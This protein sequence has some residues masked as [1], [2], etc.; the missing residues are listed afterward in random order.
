MY[1][2]DLLLNKDDLVP[3]TTIL[4]SCREFIHGVSYG[5]FQ[6][7]N[8]LVM[9]LNCHKSKLRSCSTLW[10]TILCTGIIFCCVLWTLKWTAWT[11]SF[12]AKTEAWIN[13]KAPS[14]QSVCNSLN[15]GF[16][17]KLTCSLISQLWCGLQLCGFKLCGLN[18]YELK[19][20]I[21]QVNTD[22]L[23]LKM[24]EEPAV[25]VIP[26]KINVKPPDHLDPK[27]SDVLDKWKSWKRQWKRYLLLSG[28]KNQPNDVK[29]ELL[30]HSLG[31]DCDDIYCGFI[32]KE[33]EDSEDPEVLI[34]KFDEYFQSGT[35]D[36]ME[37]MKF[38]RRRQ[39]PD[40]T[41]E[42]FLSDLRIMIKTC[43]FC[44]CQQD[45]HIMD[46]ILD[47]L[48]DE[49]TLDKL[50]AESTLDLKTVIN[51]CRAAETTASN[52]KVAH[53]S[54]KVNKLSTK[55]KS[56]STKSRS[57]KSHSEKAISD[58]KK[59]SKPQKTDSKS[60]EMIALC[61]FCKGSQERKKEKCPAWGQQCSKCKMMNHYAD[62]KACRERRRSRDKKHKVHAV[63]YDS[64]D[65]SDDSES[66]DGSVCSVTVANKVSLDS[67]NSGPLY[68]ALSID[69]QN[70]RHQIDN[71]STVCVLPRKYIGDRKIEKADVKLQVYNGMQLK[72]LGRCR[73]KVRNTKTRQKWNVTYVVIE[74]NLTPLIGRYAAERMGLITV[75]YDTFQ[76]VRAVQSLSLTQK[77]SDVFD[78]NSLGTFDSKP[79]KLV[80]SADA[81][82]VV[83]PAR[84]LPESLRDQVH[85]ELMQLV[86]NKVIAPQENPTNWCNQMVVGEK[87]NGDIRICL[88]PTSLNTFLKREH[89]KLPTLKDV[90]P[91]F[92]GAKVF[93]SCDLK[94][95]FWHLELDEQS[96]MLT[97][98]ATSWG[99][100]RWLRLPFGLNVSSEIFQRSLHQALDDLDGIACVA[101]DIIVFGSSQE[102]HDR[103]LEEL[104]KR[105]QSVG[106][107]LNKE[108][109]KFNI[110]E[111]LFMGH[112]ISKD[113]LK[114][115]PA[116]TEAIL[117]MPQPQCKADVERL[118]G[119]V[120]Y[121]SRFIPK[122]TEVFAP[123]SQLIKN[124]T[125]QWASAQQESFDTLKKLVVNAPTL[126]YFDPSKPLVIQTDAS[127]NG[128]GVVALQNDQPLAYASRALSAIERRYATIEK[129]MLA[130]VYGLEHL[131]QFTYGRP[132]FVQSDHRPLAS[133]LKKPLEKVPKRLQGMVM[134]VLAYDIELSYLPGTKMVLADALSRAYLKNKDN[135]QADIEKINALSY[136]P[137][138]QE[139]INKILEATQND[140]S[141]QELQ[142][143]VITS[144]PDKS[145]ISA[146]LMPLYHCRD[147]LHVTD[148][149]LFKGERLIIP[150]SLQQSM[151]KHVHKGH[152]GIES[153]LR[154]A[155]ESMYWHGMNNDVKQMVQNCTTCCQYQSANTKEPLIPHDIPDRPWAKIGIDLCEINGKDYVVTVCY[156]S[157]FIE[158]DRL[159]STTSEA[160]IRKL[161]TH[162]ARYGIPT[163]IIS[164]NGPQFVASQFKQFCAD[165]EIDHV[166]SS[167]HY[168]KSNGK[169]E[170]AVKVAKRA[171]KKA[172]DS[173]EDP[174]LALLMIR[175]AP[176]QDL[177][178]SPAQRLFGRR[179]RTLLPSTEHLLQEQTDHRI[180]KHKIKKRQAKQ[181]VYYD[182]HAKSLPKLAQGTSIVVKP[183]KKG[184]HKWKPAT[185]IKELRDRSY[186]IKYQNGTTAVRNR[187]H[188]RPAPP[189]CEKD[190]LRRAL[191]SI[192]CQPQENQRAQAPPERFD[193]PLN[194]NNPPSQDDPD[195]LV[196]ND[197]V[198]LV[199]NDPPRR[200]S[201]PT[202]HPKKLND[203]VL[204]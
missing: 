31:P 203:Y 137:M 42:A 57:D 121:L 198:P 194:P 79:V 77:Y 112:V 13:G 128:L 35:R 144:W 73:I 48:K 49:E 22:F 154:L 146:D 136:V 160:V 129:E 46:R 23:T 123:M 171:V 5:I 4:E 195:P 163:T 192:S 87:K 30:L 117:K 60:V 130:I 179:L 170:A 83:K 85:S 145:E 152:L 93:S 189:H 168:P 157:N 197:P 99:R 113:G 43:G 8:H 158:L 91:R 166:T 103:N 51:K 125:W 196:P 20:C 124:N 70:V 95:G 86:E 111:V 165:W 127:A 131:H 9:P 101:D 59:K 182:K 14:C 105:C 56:R 147:E 143:Y 185:V 187:A 188:I 98:M 106:I 109:S 39:Q 201:R 88:D 55:E 26:L 150:K 36:F 76:Q 75:N 181:K 1:F 155:R 10:T 6:C 63:N 142:D 156:Y 169:A 161:K 133:I 44:N 66:T 84:T 149:L 78:S 190:R 69:G 153:C 29:S 164:D 173:N 40:E 102:E 74:D 52:L 175:N 200:S 174:Y 16:T 15:R 132:V 148:G 94:H 68:C 119:M 139:K 28:S 110:P 81:S 47:G 58:K 120:N 62:S 72:A 126:T 135:P 90:L 140:H 38:H 33:G 25:P 138:T 172:L 2:D 97:T 17:C 100:F 107:R 53:K 65:S 12:P 61:K 162:C 108:K 104:L 34:T 186:K 159:Y 96:S 180:V 11:R 193:E 141:L 82:P 118:R 199:L 115:D 177:D 24:A 67:A 191:D 116:K 7:L 71:G 134:R 41:F 114:V 92:N 178:T 80:L 184:D 183:D 176:Q 32:F 3:L 19:F 64:Y 54:E 18:F 202:S 204:K 21:A 151:L 45:Q 27:A 122:L 37:R 50:L 167:P 89:Y